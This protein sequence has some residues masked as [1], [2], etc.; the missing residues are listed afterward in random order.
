MQL[1]PSTAARFCV[2]DAFDSEQNLR[3]GL[4][5]LR[6]LLARYGGDV[7]LASAAYNAG[8][9]AVD[10]YGGVPPYEETRAY[11]RRVGLLY[12]KS[13]HRFNS[14]ARDGCAK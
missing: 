11:V 12:G 7:A 8:E 6:W 4:A 10:Q 14:Q 9:R 3:G 2:L 5:Y 13:S 1:I